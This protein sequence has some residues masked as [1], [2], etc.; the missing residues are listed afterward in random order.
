MFFAILL[1]SSGLLNTKPAPV[2]VD[3]TFG[4]EGPFRFLVDTGSE[5]NLIDPSLAARLKLQ[6][7]FRVEVVTQNT[8]RLLPALRVN[9]LRIGRKELPETEMVFHDLVE[10]RRF[11]SSILGCWE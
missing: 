4:T 6:P 3:V 8:R 11:D 7:E 10:A 9:T 2:F 5:T 1:F